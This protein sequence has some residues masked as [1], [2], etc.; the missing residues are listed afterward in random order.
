MNRP[1]NVKRELKNKARMKGREPSKLWVRTQ[2]LFHRV[3][4]FARSLTRK[5]SPDD[6]ERFRDRLLRKEQRGRAKLPA[7]SIDAR[8]KLQLALSQYR[9]RSFDGPVALLAS[10]ERDPTDPW[11]SLLPQLRIHHAF[12]THSEIASAIAAR[13]MQSIFDAALA[14]P[15]PPARPELAS[16]VATTSS[17]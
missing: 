17:G 11:A 9:P 12:S 3:G 13:L 10:P 16:S 5:D 6:L 7:E 4:T 1:V 15:S 2:L 8:A 14:A